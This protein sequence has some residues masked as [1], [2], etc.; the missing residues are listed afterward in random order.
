MMHR[1]ATI[2]AALAAGAVL[3]GLW[4]TVASSRSAR[5]PDPPPPVPAL[6][7]ASEV[8]LLFAQPYL[9]DEGY[10]HWWRAEQP[11]VTAG[12]LLVLAVD[13][14]LV[15]PR[16]G[17]EPVLY[18]GDQT[19]ERVNVGFVPGEIPPG[20]RAHVVALVPAGPGPDDLP[21]LDLARA[22]I[23]FGTPALPEQVDE[24]RIAGELALA[25]ARGA[26]P[27]PGPRVI[28]ARR[29]GGGTL[30]L[31]DYPALQRCAAELVRRWSPGE[32]DLVQSLLAPPP[33]QARV[34]R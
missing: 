23:W 3:L 5:D 34:G 1:Q 4:A 25:L 20:A 2:A 27:L 14:D 16:Q 9:L 7:V 11:F 10:T 8:D 13:S 12:W 31:P 24:A 32:E 28:A 17:Y 26:R 19:A 21:R 6:S 18:V 15:H 30:Y 33:E 22:P 29:A